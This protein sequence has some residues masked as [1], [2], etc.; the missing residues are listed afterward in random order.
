MKNYVPQEVKKK[1]K[2]FKVVSIHDDVWQKPSQ[3]C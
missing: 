1:K 3:Y 2:K